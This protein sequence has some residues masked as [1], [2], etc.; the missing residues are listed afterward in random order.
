MR[1]SE[2]GCAGVMAMG[3]GWC[4]TEDHCFQC[5]SITAVLCR[6]IH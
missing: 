4:E 3:L 5:T 2:L 1:K 6:N